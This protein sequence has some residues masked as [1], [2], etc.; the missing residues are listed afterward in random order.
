MLQARQLDK[1]YR[2]TEADHLV[3][4]PPCVFISTSNIDALSMLP[5]SEVTVL[6]FEPVS[7]IDRREGKEKEK[8]F[9]CSQSFITF[10]FSFTLLVSFKLC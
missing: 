4:I 3:G 10:D 9:P 7:C 1:Q 2:Y 6:L 8:R 5:I